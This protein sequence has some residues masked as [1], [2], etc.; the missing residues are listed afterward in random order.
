MEMIDREP[1]VTI[2]LTLGKS[3]KIVVSGKP[4]VDILA[5]SLKAAILAIQQVSELPDLQTG[6]S[7]AKR[8]P[9][10]I[11]QHITG[12]SNKELALILLYY[13]GP[14]SKDLINQ[15]SRELGKEIKRDWL[16]TELYRSMREFIISEDS[17]EGVKMYRLTERGRIEAE[18]II[19]E[20]MGLD[21]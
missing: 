4:N 6:I 9:E 1:K 13:E 17:A 14:M 10:H 12:M 7:P 16:D 5:E 15:R 11:I 21:T 2:E 19:A 20:K 18:R 3:I 8:V